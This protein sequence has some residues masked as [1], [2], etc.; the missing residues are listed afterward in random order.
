MWLAPTHS[1]GA[2]CNIIGGVSSPLLAN[3]FLHY[4]FDAWMRKQFPDLQFERYCDDGVVHCHSEKQAQVVRDAIAAR[5]TQWRLELHPD[6]TR[7]VYCEDENRRASYANER[8]D[9]LGYTFGPRP[10]VGRGKKF[11]NF[12]PAVSGDALNEM[13]KGC[14]ASEST[15]AVTRLWTTLHRW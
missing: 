12:L 1:I 5:L 15:V 2:F 3:L 7:I 11:T 8:F 10:A 6:K 9:F 14:G 13:G 4:A